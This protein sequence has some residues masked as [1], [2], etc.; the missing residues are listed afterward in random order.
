[1]LLQLWS[2]ERFSIGRPFVDQE[3]YGEHYYMAEEVEWPTVGLFWVRRQVLTYLTWKYCKFC[4]YF[5]CIDFI[6]N[7]QQR[8]YKN[9]QS[10]KSYPEF[11]REF[12]ELTDDLVRWTPYSDEELA[13]RAPFGLPALCTRDRQYWLTRKALV[14]DCC[15]EE[16]SPH[17]VMR[18]FDLR[19][20]FPIPIHH[21]V[22]VQ[23]HK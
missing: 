17:R 20:E 23:V 22:P 16:Y 15:V 6:I 2:W 18:Q 12:D 19:Q 10:K 11:V 5:I 1:M 21:T 9:K 13:K 7:F 14:F 4:T 8:R 3:P